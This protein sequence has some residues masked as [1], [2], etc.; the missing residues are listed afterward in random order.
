VKNKKLC[1]VCGE[2]A[3]N[4]LF[5]AFF[6]GVGIRELSMESKLIPEVKKFIRTITLEEAESV[7]RRVSKIHRT[8]EIRSYLQ[9]FYDTHN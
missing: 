8:E 5:T 7:A 2:L 3:G 4:S 6:V 1:S 9:K